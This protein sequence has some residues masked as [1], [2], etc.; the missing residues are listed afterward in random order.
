MAKQRIEVIQSFPFSVEKLYGF[1]SEHENLGAIFPAKIK[2]IRDGQGAVN[3]VGSVRRIMM[4]PGVALEE[5]V[6]KA[7]PNELIEYTITKGGW[8]INSHLGVMKFYEHERGSRL[9]YTIDL[10]ATV[11]GAAWVLK[12]V[13]GGSIRSGL[14]KLAAKGV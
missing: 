2:R 12:N 14:K 10:G 13:L 7:E 6:T 3:G 5:T 9:H 8:P 1:L 11:P 4:A